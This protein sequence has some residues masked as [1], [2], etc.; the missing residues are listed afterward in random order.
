MK[1]FLARI[2]RN[3]P[4][5]IALCSMFIAALS[6]G[7]ALITQHNDVVYRE[8]GI[9]PLV[10]LLSSEINFS[11]RIINKGLGPAVIR[12]V[13]FAIGKKCYS[14]NEMSDPEWVERVTEFHNEA[15]DQLYGETF[16][17]MN[18]KLDRGRGFGIELGMPNP[19]EMIRPGEEIVLLKLDEAHLAEF[20]KKMDQLDH[21]AVIK[22][23][24]AFG[25][26][27]RNLPISISYCSATGVFCE[28]MAAS[29]GPCA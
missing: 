26:N 25:L 5:I 8:A 17:A 19:S 12:D 16:K 27:G 28:V 10:A 11:V 3:A 13:K 24:R 9:R 23:R 20:K 4:T 21:E 1:R 6:L 18:F 7:V 29:V 14:G 2:G 22:A 15:A